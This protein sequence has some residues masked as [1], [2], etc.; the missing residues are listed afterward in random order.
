[1][2]RRP[3]RSTLFPYTTLFRSLDTTPED[4]DACQAAL[5]R[6]QGAHARD[7]ANPLACNVA[8]R[9]GADEQRAAGSHGVS[10]EWHQQL[11]KRLAAEFSTLPRGGVFTARGP[12]EIGFVAQIVVFE[13]GNDE[14]VGVEIARLPGRCRHG[15]C[16]VHVLHLRVRSLWG[17][18]RRLRIEGAS[19]RDQS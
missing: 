15:R 16:L 11:L 18:V 3:P 10:G 19:S 14:E 2:S 8:A 9:A 6:R 5:P 12:I 13:D 4:R 17:K 7:P 1:M